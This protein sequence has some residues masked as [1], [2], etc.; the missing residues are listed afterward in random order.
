MINKILTYLTYIGE[1][2]CVKKSLTNFFSKNYKLENKNASVNN[3]TRGR[4]KANRA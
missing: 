3:H 2:K 1:E 4:K